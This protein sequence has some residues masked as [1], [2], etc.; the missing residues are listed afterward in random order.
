MPHQ[1]LITTNKQTNIHRKGPGNE[2]KEKQLHHFE[3]LLLFPHNIRAYT[4]DRIP[5]LSVNRGL[6]ADWHT[7][8]GEFWSWIA[9]FFLLYV[10]TCWFP[11]WT[12]LLAISCLILCRRGVVGRYRW[13]G[14][15][16]HSV[17]FRMDISQTQLL[18]LE[19]RRE[20]TH[21]VISC[22]FCVVYENNTGWLWGNQFGGCGRVLHAG[23][24]SK[25][26]CCA[27]TQMQT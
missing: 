6:F 26:S 9:F 7:R 21:R 20:K 12:M 11:E 27:A 19:E 15:M 25:A 4:S 8:W 17:Q 16:S 18:P 23:M 2:N 24:H 22:S 14:F 3:Y 10:I 13:V 1:K 5:T